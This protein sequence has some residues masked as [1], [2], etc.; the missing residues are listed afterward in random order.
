MNQSRLITYQ[1][2][3][4][5]TCPNGCP[6]T[7]LELGSE[8]QSLMAIFGSPYKYLRCGKCHF[9]E[10]LKAEPQFHVRDVV[11]A[12]NKLVLEHNATSTNNPEER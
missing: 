4:L 3:D 8:H 1:G 7:E 12:W 9:G 11:G 2:F 10:E 6:E 5:R